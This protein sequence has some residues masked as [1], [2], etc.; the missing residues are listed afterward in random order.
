[1][2]SQFRSADQRSFWLGILIAVAFDYAVLVIILS[3]FN[4]TWAETFIFA[5]LGVLG[6]YVLQLAYGLA[7]AARYALIFYLFERDRRV[8][9][10]ADQMV[11]LDLPHPQRFY[12]NAEE[13][14]AEV[15]ASDQASSD[16]KLF[17]GATIGRLAALRETSRPLLAMCLA[18]VLEAAISRY[19]DDPSV[20]P[21]TLTTTRTT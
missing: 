17:A 14:L 6:L 8:A 10:V 15:V 13:Y 21:F 16:A 2:A 4:D 11:A 18:D 3:I 20:P 7:S 9:Q 5:G 19:S 12:L 1:M